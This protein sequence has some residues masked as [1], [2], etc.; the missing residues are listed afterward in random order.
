[1]NSDQLT[2]DQLEVLLGAAGAAPS[3]HNTQP[4]RFDVDGSVINVHLDDSRTL[5]AEDPEGRA[6][7]IGIGAAVFNLRVAAAHLGLDSWFGLAPYEGEPDLMARVVFAP[8]TAAVPPLGLLYRE[9]PRR[10]TDRAPARPVDIASPVRAE[11]QRAAFA[12]GADLTFVPAERL[13]RVLW[14]EVDADLRGVVD[15]ARITERRHWIGGHRT[16]DGVPAAAL[17]PRSIAYP[18]VVRDLSATPAERSRPAARFEANPVLAVL[19]TE[20]DHASD[21]LTAGMALQRVLLVATRHGLSASF[22]NQSLEY[23]DLR[24]HVQELTG[25]PGHAHMLMRLLPSVAHE[26]TP[27]RPVADT[28]TPAAE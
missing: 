12:E 21:Q 27:R 19:S 13:D 23:D 28:L 1:M 11:L 15:S 8:S 9:I 22:L 3:M 4:W 24:R 7:R 18:A 2:P 10:H 25:K 14:L 16:A 5:P 6:A 17:G 26:P 20:G